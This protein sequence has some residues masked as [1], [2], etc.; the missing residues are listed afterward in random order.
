M[1]KRDSDN[2]EAQHRS[3]YEKGEENIREIYD[4]K[5]KN[6]TNSEGGPTI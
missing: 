4:I 5:E 6:C 1:Q 2:L 3:I